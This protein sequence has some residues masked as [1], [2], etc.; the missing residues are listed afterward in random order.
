MNYVNDNFVVIVNFLKTYL[1]QFL[2]FLNKEIMCEVC[3]A[4]Y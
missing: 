2:L 4:R 1:P 3:H